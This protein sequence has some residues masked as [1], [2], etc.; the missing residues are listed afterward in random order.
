[1]PK[2]TQKKK[3]SNH[4]ITLRSEQLPAVQASI[5]R[6]VTGGGACELYFVVKRA[7]TQDDGKT[8]KYS[9]KMYPR[10]AMAMNE[11]TE[12]AV[13]WIATHP[14]AADGPLSPSDDGQQRIAVSAP[15]QPQ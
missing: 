10:H 5:F 15:M 4:V 8:F 11:V 13:E 14:E 1:M 2:Q 9:A 12:A 3:D 7:Y 6:R